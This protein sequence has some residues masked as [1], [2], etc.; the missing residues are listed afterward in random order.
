[1]NASDLMPPAAR[2]DES[3]DPQLE[4][5]LQ[6]DG[7]SRWLDLE[8]WILERLRHNEREATCALSLMRD[9]ARA[10]S[11]MALSVQHG[12]AAGPA[13]ATISFSPETYLNELRAQAYSNSMA[14]ALYRLPYSGGAAGI[15]CDPHTFSEREMRR[16]IRAVSLS[17]SDLLG[18]R[19]V[20]LVPTPETNEHIA[21]WLAAEFG[22]TEARVSVSGK[23]A[24]AHGI[25]LDRLHAMGIVEVVRESLPEREIGIRGARVALQG[26]GRIARTVAAEL[27]GLGARVIAVADVSGGLLDREGLDI[28]AVEQYVMRQGVVLGYPK[29]EPLCNADV[30]ELD[31]DALVLLAAPWQ[32]TARNAD[33]IR[34]KVIVEG[35]PHGLTE[36]ARE[37]LDARG[38]IMASS[39]FCLGARLFAASLELSS[40]EQANATRPAYNALVRRRVRRAFSE[41]REAK[42]HWQTNL[43][44]TAEMLAVDRLA[45]ELREQG[46]G[47]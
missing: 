11:C 7:L 27:H 47:L 12:R 6:L 24:G 45:C 8:D 38:T 22:D 21:G 40:G 19:A 30:L 25:D 10:E 35:V 46:L 2:L 15:V 43:W 41:I 1:M 13:L 32:I 36:T 39:I 5:Q 4:S 23:P 33:G 26:F 37:Q 14:C 9:D 16:V 31:C 18:C 29:A 17:G 44:I 42:R 3:L 28:N 34:A 20:A